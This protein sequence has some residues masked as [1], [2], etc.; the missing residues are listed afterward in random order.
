M[1]GDLCE[2]EARLLDTAYSRPGGASQCDPI[3]KKKRR[4]SSNGSM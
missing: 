2:F 4:E 3:L 1:A